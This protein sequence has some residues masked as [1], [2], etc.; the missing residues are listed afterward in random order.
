MIGPDFII[1]GAMKSATTTLHEQLARQPGITM[2]EPKEPGFFSHDDH[3]RQGWDRYERQLR[4]TPETVLNGESSTYYTKLPTYPETVGRMA[5]DLPD[6]T[7][8]IY[9]M[10]HPVDRLISHYQHEWLRGSTHGDIHQTLRS[11]RTLVAYSCY[12]MQLEPYLRTFGPE[13]VLPVFQAALR[14]RPQAELERICRFIGYSSRPTWLSGNDENVSAERLRRDPRRQ[15]LASLPGFG[16]IRRVTPPGVERRVR[17]LWQRRAA[18]TLTGEEL[19]ELREVFDRDLAILGSWLALELTC[20][21]FDEL[22]AVAT[23]AWS[24]AAPRRAAVP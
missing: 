23:P 8:F 21:R 13:R 20:E 3:Y 22:A 18:P 15:F 2:S 1:I 14:V 10:R 9:V 11:D 24:A 19:G 6:T 16:L 5:R 17:A 7:R 12:S 4:R